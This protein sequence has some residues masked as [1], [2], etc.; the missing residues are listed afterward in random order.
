[1]QQQ[2]HDCAGTY[3]LS[4]E[5]NASL[6]PTNEDSLLHRSDLLPPQYR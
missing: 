6:D 2:L 4:L 1:M 5:R 3:G